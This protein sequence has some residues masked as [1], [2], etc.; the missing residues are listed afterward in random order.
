MR[1]I[2]GGETW[3]HNLGR[4][5]VFYLS[6]IYFEQLAAGYT[7]EII[8]GMI[9]FTWCIVKLYC[10]VTFFRTWIILI[11]P[12]YIDHIGIKNFSWIWVVGDVTMT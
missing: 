9:F 12:N 4:L 8:I 2:I 1:C 7:T 10:Y 3:L 6:D 11:V 5:A